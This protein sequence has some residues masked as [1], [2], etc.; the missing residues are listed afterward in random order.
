MVES[1]E[2]AKVRKDI[3][4]I[5]LYASE[6]ERYKIIC[7]NSPVIQEFEASMRR[8]CGELGLANYPAIE[9]AMNAHP[10][11]M[12]QC[13][14]CEQSPPTQHQM[15]FRSML[16]SATERSLE[17]NEYERSVEEEHPSA[18]VRRGMGGFGEMLE[19]SRMGTER[20]P[21]KNEDDIKPIVRG[22][23]MGFQAMLNGAAHGTI[24][25]SFQDVEPNPPVRRDGFLGQLEDAYRGTPESR[26]IMRM[27]HG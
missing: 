21:E 15:G 22:W 7:G 11:H 4:R 8:V 12:C 27:A 23:G 20:S 25:R 2:E 26:I 3:E 19:E 1:L 5:I 17:K 10:E 16:E 9:R 13:R 6:L 24:E 14:T 18:S